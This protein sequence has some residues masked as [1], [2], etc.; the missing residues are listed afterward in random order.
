MY[1]LYTYQ[2]R[3]CYLLN[4]LHTHPHL[5]ELRVKV[6]SVLKFNVII[7]NQN[8]S[9]NPGCLSFIPT[10]AKKIR[11]NASDQFTGIADQF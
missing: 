8:Q 7:R 9:R 1:T 6:R 5:F 2:L 3:C 10:T 11:F 4:R